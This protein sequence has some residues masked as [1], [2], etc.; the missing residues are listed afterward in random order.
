MPVPRDSQN[1]ID[2][3]HAI[4]SKRQHVSFSTDDESEQDTKAKTERQWDIEREGKALTCHA[5][6]ETEGRPRGGG[7]VY[8]I[9]LVGCPLVSQ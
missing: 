1:S 2:G 9:S 3:Y 7:E 8:G 5:Q 4:S 6:K